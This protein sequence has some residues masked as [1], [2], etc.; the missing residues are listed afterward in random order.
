[1][2]IYIEDKTT[3]VKGGGKDT[4]VLLTVDRKHVGESLTL[5]KLN[6]ERKDDNIGGLYQKNIALQK[7]IDD[8]RKAKEKVGGELYKLREQAL[9]GKAS[10]DDPMEKD[11]MIRYDCKFAN[12]NTN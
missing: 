5:E 3:R 12:R 10:T 7:H 8:E 11:G 9:K 1:M 6:V 4:R 2:T